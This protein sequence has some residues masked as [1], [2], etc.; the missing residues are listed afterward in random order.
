MKLFILAVTAGLVSCQIIPGGVVQ[1]DP[2]NP[3][4]RKPARVAATYTDNQTTQS[5]SAQYGP[6]YQVVAASTQIVAGTLYRMT[7]KFTNAQQIVT[8]CDVAVLEQPWL[9]YIGLSGTPECRTSNVK[10]QVLGGYQYVNKTSPEVH[11]SASFAVDAINTQ[12]NSFYILIEV[13]SAQQQIV[14]GINY[15]LVLSVANTSSCRNY[16]SLLKC[17]VNQRK[18]ICD[19]VVWD[20]PW[21]SKR[22]QL[23]S[24]HCK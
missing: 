3:M 21:R 24:F 23:T 2:N 4:F 22:Y 7:L 18:L 12:S 5:L 6:R 16:G 13:I 20:Q 10:K 1:Q 15:K 8:L 19:V 11:A 14:A 9:N 17:P